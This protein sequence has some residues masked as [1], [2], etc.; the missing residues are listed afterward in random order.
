VIS[1]FL[2]PQLHLLNMM[3]GVVLWPWLRS[4]GQ[5]TNVPQ[6]ARFPGSSWAEL[7]RG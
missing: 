7:R 5:E 1:D 6:E 4:C 3:F 2:E